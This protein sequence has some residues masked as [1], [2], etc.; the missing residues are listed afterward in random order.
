MKRVEFP[1]IGHRASPLAMC[2]ADGRNRFEPPTAPSV[3]AVVEASFPPYARP[4]RSGHLPF[5]F[6]L[7]DGRL[8]GSRSAS[9]RY[10]ELSER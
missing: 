8:A 9:L 4:K 10:Q 2:C 5:S 1:L 6:G 7:S 3:D